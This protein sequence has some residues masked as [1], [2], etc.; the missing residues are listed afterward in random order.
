MVTERLIFWG[1]G[2]GWGA[3]ETTVLEMPS[4]FVEVF[5]PVQSVTDATGAFS[6][7]FVSWM[8]SMRPNISIPNVTFDFD[9]DDFVN[10]SVIA[11]CLEPIQDVPPPRGIALWLIVAS[12][13]TVIARAAVVTYKANRILRTYGQTRG[14]KKDL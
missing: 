3:G 1:T 13:V 14:F 4:R 2:L 10:S 9:I 7:R 6:W 5:D 8:S 12:F 11:S